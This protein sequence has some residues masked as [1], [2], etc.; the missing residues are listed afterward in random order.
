MKKGCGEDETQ[1]NTGGK[2][3]RA[4]QRGEGSQSY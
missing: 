2:K 1:D 3:R 4:G